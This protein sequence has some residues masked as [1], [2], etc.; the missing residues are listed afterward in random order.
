MIRC[1]VE[2]GTCPLDYNYLCA[3]IFTRFAQARSPSTSGRGGPLRNKSVSF[4]A[5]PATREGEEAS[6][7][8]ELGS[9]SSVSTQSSGG[10]LTKANRHAGKVRRKASCVV[11]LKRYLLTS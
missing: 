6:E 5:R 2:P 4:H 8:S 10:I 3:A 1:S 9:G 11:V 7:A